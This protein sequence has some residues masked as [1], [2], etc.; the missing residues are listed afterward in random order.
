MINKTT[1][2]F[3]L[4][5][6]LLDL[7]SEEF[8][9]INNYFCSL[10]ADNLFD[11]T[12]FSSL[13][14]NFVPF[15]TDEIETDFVDY[16]YPSTTNQRFTLFNNSNSDSS[17]CIDSIHNSEKEGIT[18]TY[19]K[20]NENNKE[21]ETGMFTKQQSKNNNIL[22]K[23]IQLFPLLTPQDE[24]NNSELLLEDLKTKRETNNKDKDQK[25]SPPRN[26]NTK[27]NVL[28]NAKTNSNVN[29]KN[30][31]KEQKRNLKSNFG[32]SVSKTQTQ[33]KYRKRGFFGNDELDENSKKRKKS[34]IVGYGKQIFKLVAGQ[35]WVISG[36]SSYRKSVP[37]TNQLVTKLG[38][39]LK[40]SDKETK[41]F[42]NNLKYL[43]TNSRRTFTEYILEILLGV[44]S[45]VHLEDDIGNE[46]EE[47]NN[48]KHDLGDWIKKDQSGEKN[49][50]QE[51]EFEQEL[52]NQDQTKDEKEN[53]HLSS[54]KQ[55]P[56]LQQ[57]SKK[58]FITLFQIAQSQNKQS[59][60]Y[61]TKQEIQKINQKE[62]EQKQELLKIYEQ[63]FSEQVLFYWFDKR[64]VD[65]VEHIFEPEL[66]TKFYKDH[67][68]AFGRSK[69]ILSS[70]VLAKELVNNLQICKNYSNL[71]DPKHNN[72]PINLYLNNRGKKQKIIKDLIVRFSLNGGKFW[73]VLS[74]DYM[75]NLKFSTQN[76]TEYFTFKSIIFHPLVVEENGSIQKYKK[77]CSQNKKV[78][79][80]QRRTIDSIINLDWCLKK[81]IF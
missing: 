77:L 41:N 9:E 38:Q 51:I 15:I 22:Y 78:V 68:F 56:N 4:E 37:Y 66:R 69:F 80:S 60:K 39:V 16:N 42:E 61:L 43:L 26:T 62:S 13:E 74:N 63:I 48:Q 49:L 28:V 33:R 58:L 44:L 8:N 73:D 2:F 23:E 32:N 45:L 72:D 24:Q 31:K 19:T 1:D 76:I 59:N 14:E 70:L 7:D 81:T 57:I 30:K 25:Q 64:F 5:E 34:N 79:T 36:G 46:E 35:M 27:R 40:A 17:F 20:I 75:S 12:N 52:E 21:L 10:T 18:N 54:L 67:F 6:K 29:T 65:Q 11:S 55:N 3:G 71:I 47:S 53:E 50:V